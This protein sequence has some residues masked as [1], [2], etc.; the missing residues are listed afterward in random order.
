M[1]SLDQFA[2]Q[3]EDNNLNNKKTPIYIEE[4]LLSKFIEDYLDFMLPEMHKQA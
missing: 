2:L 1:N 4:L 3:R